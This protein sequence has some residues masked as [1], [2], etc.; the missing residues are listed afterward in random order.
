MPH[1]HC[2]GFLN[3]SGPHRVIR[4][5]SPVRAFRDT[6]VM[7]AD[8]SRSVSGDNEFG[9]PC[10]LGVSSQKSTPLANTLSKAIGTG[11]GLKILGR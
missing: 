9:H 4:S 8:L 11:P 1:R 7:R 3:V 10:D 2:C 5:S 6:V